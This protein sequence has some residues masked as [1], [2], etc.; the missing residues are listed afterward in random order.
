MEQKIIWFEQNG[1][2]DDDEENYCDIKTESSDELDQEKQ[3][4]EERNSTTK[5]SVKLGWIHRCKF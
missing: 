4:E 3:I 2:C 1:N 5:S